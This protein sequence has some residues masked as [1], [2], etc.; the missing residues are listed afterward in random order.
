MARWEITRFR[1]C[2]TQSLSL[3]QGLD[4]WPLRLKFDNLTQFT[5]SSRDSLLSPQWLESLLSS[6]SSLHSLTLS[7]LGNINKVLQ[8]VCNTAWNLKHLTIVGVADQLSIEPLAEDLTKFGPSLETITFSWD[9]EE[10]HKILSL[11]CQP[12]CDQEQLQR[13][14]NAIACCVPPH[15]ANLSNVLLIA[16]NGFGT[17]SLYSNLFFEVP[18]LSLAQFVLE[19]ISSSAGGVNR[20]PKS[21]HHNE[22]ALAHILNLATSADGE[23][24]RVIILLAA[25]ASVLVRQPL[26][27]FRSTPRIGCA[28]HCAR[29]GPKTTQELYKC[30]EN[31][32][33]AISEDNWNRLRTEDGFTPLHLICEFAAW[34]VHYEAISVHYPDVLL[35]TCNIFGMTP[36]EAL[37]SRRVGS[38][39]NADSPHLVAEI[40]EFLLIQGPPIGDSAVI[41]VLALALSFYGERLPHIPYNLVLKLQPLFNRI[42]LQCQASGGL[43][44]PTIR[45]HV[46]ADA[47]RWKMAESH[48]LLGAMLFGREILPFL[49][50]S[51]SIRVLSCSLLLMA[52]VYGKLPHF[53]RDVQLLLDKGADINWVDSNFSNG[54]SFLYQLVA[55]SR[56]AAASRK[57]GFAG[58]VP[59]LTESFQ[60]EFWSVFYY[61]C[62]L[63]AELLLEGGPVSIHQR[64]WALLAGTSFFEGPWSLS[65]TQLARFILWIIKREENLDKSE[66]GL[67][68]LIELRVAT[69]PRIEGYG[70]KLQTF[71]P[72]LANLLNSEI[73]RLF[74][75]SKRS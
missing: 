69:R 8:K 61:Y 4:W 28:L 62:D 67:L 17:F 9:L 30:I 57:E 10:Y 46:K 25:G 48:A 3:F 39:P 14:L 26:P 59:D 40:L 52:S 34:K 47:F 22:T 6:A 35:D 45:D 33:K 11:V 70:E 42:I 41:R 58:I 13:R 1:N 7:T 71:E 21:S 63:G 72:N 43:D 12:Y 2:P 24:D 16:E 66:D 68:G 73:N 51:Q 44:G 18:S 37:H 49:V 38:R 53:R 60:D 74:A 31:D 29:I 27:R 55:F 19:K 75:A 20:A 5:F 56:S 23:L 50:E 32:W 15:L 36:L 65:S 64:A 54:A